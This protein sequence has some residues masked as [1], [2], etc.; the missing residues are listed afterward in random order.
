MGWT[1]LPAGAN[2]VIENAI[3]DKNCRVG[4][5]V[6]ITNKEGISEANHEDDGWYVRSGIPIVLKNATIPDGFEF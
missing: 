6:K 3:L 1:E 4:K 2:S 5:N